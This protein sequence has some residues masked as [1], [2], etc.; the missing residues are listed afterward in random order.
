[1]SEIDNFWNNKQYILNKEALKKEAREHY[2]EDF[3]ANFEKWKNN[4]QDLNN[5]MSEFL[6]NLEFDMNYWENLSYDKFCQQINNEIEKWID[7]NNDINTSDIELIVQYVIDDH[8]S[9]ILEKKSQEE[10][11]IA[12]LLESIKNVKF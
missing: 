6:K 11:T 4:L 3:I 1:M 2:T 10:Y 12:S 8:I 9:A 7:S 5:T